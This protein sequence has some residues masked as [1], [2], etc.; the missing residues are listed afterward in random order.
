MGMA[1]RT[2]AGSLTDQAGTS[3]HDATIFALASGAGRAGV[4]VVRISGSACSS[5]CRDLSGK[6]VSTPRKAVLRVLADPVSGDVI[7]KG[8]IIWF[9]G[10]MSFTGEDVLELHVHG[11]PAVLAG[12]FEAL[13]SRRDVRP[14][15]AGEFSRR[16][17]L[18][19]KLDLTEAEGLADL[20]AA[21][22][23]QQARQARRQMDGSLGQ[24][25][26]RWHE[27]LTGALAHLEAE[28]DFAPEEEVPEGLMSRIIPALDRL[29][30][31][32][33]EHLGD[34]R[35]GERL[36]EGLQ[37]ALV[38]PPNAGKS[39]LIN[40]LSRR[41]VAIVTDIP[42]TTRDVLDVPLDLDGYPITIVDMAGLRKTDDPVEVLGVE[43]ARGRARDADFILAL[44]D[45]AA[46]PHV[47]QETLA[48]VD[49]RTVVLLNKIDLLDQPFQIDIDGQEAIG[50]SCHRGDGIDDL[51]NRLSSL[52]QHAMPPGDAPA[53]TR[54]R[55]RDAL[56]DVVAALARVGD[57]KP[58][59][60][61]A[62]MAEDLRVALGAMGRITGKV[63]VEDLLD[64]IFGEFCIG[65]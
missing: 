14:A 5:I 52:A 64:R 27:A 55:H 37:V 16:A 19:G 51:V 11:G 18:N 9:P 28:I 30:S 54:A 10:P 15:E 3:S 17:F 38:G 36:R 6:D 61:L 35:R 41:D 8:L 21:E 25:Y 22:T 2:S 59:K 46:W 65:K 45:G 49:D 58:I 44:F 33:E 62:L 42:G 34:D 1:D 40:V 53:L 32:I 31:E 43:R 7:D 47:D 57:G 48:L 63:G 23:R 24:L 13:M 29:R 50:I 12:L 39:T 60:E 26:G 4:A 20:V 56:T